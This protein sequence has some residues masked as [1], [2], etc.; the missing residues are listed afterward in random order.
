MLSGSTIKGEGPLM[1]SSAHVGLLEKLG[2]LDEGLAKMMRRVRKT[3]FT[4]TVTSECCCS[5]CY[6]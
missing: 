5:C 1:S 4:A 3:R 6:E 2:I